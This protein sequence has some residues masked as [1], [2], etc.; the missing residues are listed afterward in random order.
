MIKQVE[1]NAP[2]Y[3]EIGAAWSRRE[4]LF[5]GMGEQPR[6]MTMA[7]NKG[8]RV[9]IEGTNSGQIELVEQVVGEEPISWTGTVKSFDYTRS[10]RS[11]MVVLAAFGL[12][13]IK[14][15]T[16]YSIP[17]RFGLNLRKVSL[18]ALIRAAAEYRG[19]RSKAKILATLAYEVLITS[20]NVDPGW[21]IL[22]VFIGGL[23]HWSW[24]YPEVTTRRLSLVNESIADSLMSRMLFF[25]PEGMAAKPAHNVVVGDGYM[26]PNMRVN[27]VNMLQS[28]DQIGK[29]IKEELWLELAAHIESYQSLELSLDPDYHKGLEAYKSA[30]GSLP[31][32]I[33]VPEK[34]EMLIYFAPDPTTLT[35]VQSAWNAIGGDP[36]TGVSISRVGIS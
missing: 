21:G 31:G 34:D 2:G 12:N 15:T 3:I 1:V 20:H 18:L 19:T 11:I 35:T 22:G 29:A 4:M 26:N 33:L 36:L 32:T 23:N 17:P 7:L 27:Y 10:Q 13:S 24:K 28:V 25:A 9:T 6:S 16:L 30:V 5:V 14:V 8:V